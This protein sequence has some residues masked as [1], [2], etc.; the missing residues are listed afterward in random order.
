MNGQLHALGRF[1]PCPSSEH[2]NLSGR[3]GEQINVAPTGTQ[4]PDRPARSRSLYRLRYPGSELLSIPLQKPNMNRWIWHDRPDR[5]HMNLNCEDGTFPNFGKSTIPELTRLARNKYFSIPVILIMI[6][7]SLPVNTDHLCPT[8]P[9]AGTD[10]VRRFGSSPYSRL[11]TTAGSYADNI[12]I[13]YTLDIKRVSG[14]SFGTRVISEI[15]IYLIFEFLLLRTV[16]TVKEGKVKV[17]P[18]LN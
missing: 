11:H 8:L 3:R 12:F 2:Q 4:T 10:C 16:H 13:Q 7:M 15:D 14:D 5:R 6:P 1:T 18:V 17:V 9:T